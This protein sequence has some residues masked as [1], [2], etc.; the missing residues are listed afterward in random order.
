MG[1][2]VCFNKGMETTWRVIRRSTTT[3][4]TLKVIESGF[5]NER[6]AQLFAQGFGRD[7]SGK[8][9]IAVERA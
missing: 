3:G 1:Y 7:E 9:L 5:R 6:E 2:Q 8:T 4:R